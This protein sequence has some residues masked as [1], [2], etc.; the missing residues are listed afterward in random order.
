ML[1]ENKTSLTKKDFM[2]AKIRRKTDP[3]LFKSSP[4]HL[5]GGAISGNKA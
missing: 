1:V 3:D 4:R 5:E 2:Q